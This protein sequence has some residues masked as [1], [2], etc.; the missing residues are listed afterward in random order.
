MR[1]LAI[2]LG[3]TSAALLTGCPSQESLCKSGVDQVC[4]RE[5]ECQPQQVQESSQF[6]AAFGTSVQN[7][8]DLLYANPLRPAGAQGIACVDVKTDAQLCSNLGISTATTF[9]LTNA[10]SCK[11]E[12]KKLE[13]SAFL[14]Q[15]NPSGPG[16]QPP[17]AICNQRCK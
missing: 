9:D 16:G 2:V 1:G 11:D 4:E 7:C 10:V 15:V 12:R 5:Y 14:A 13:C 3:V 8:K 6:Q 17:P